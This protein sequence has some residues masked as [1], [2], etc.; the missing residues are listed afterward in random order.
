M[1]GNK[2]STVATKQQHIEDAEIQGEKEQVYS[3]KKPR[4]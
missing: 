3:E 2:N 4:E 1:S